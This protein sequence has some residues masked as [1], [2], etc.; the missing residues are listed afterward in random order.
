MSKHSKQD[1]LNAILSAYRAGNCCEACGVWCPFEE[2]GSNHHIHRKATLAM[3]NN[4]DNW[5][6]LC[7]TCH[8]MAHDQPWLFEDAKQ[9]IIAKRLAEQQEPDIVEEVE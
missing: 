7:F 6:W 1:K 8:R 4:P 2:S 5:T 9:R 3:R